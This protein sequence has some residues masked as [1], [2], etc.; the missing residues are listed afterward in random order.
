MIDQSKQYWQIVNP[1]AILYALEIMKNILRGQGGKRIEQQE[2]ISSE[3]QGPQNVYK[4]G[5]MVTLDCHMIYSEQ[6]IL[7][8]LFVETQAWENVFSILLSSY[9]QVKVNRVDFNVVS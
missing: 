1:S 6:K 4:I 3:H 8:F 5:Q 7:E 9:L 2:Q